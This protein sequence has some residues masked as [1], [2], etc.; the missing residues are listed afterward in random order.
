MKPFFVAF[1]MLMLASCNADEGKV[2]DVVDDNYAGGEVMCKQPIEV[3]YSKQKLTA[4]GYIV[5]FEKSVDLEVVSA[6]YL[7]KYKDLEIYSNF[8]SLNGFHGNSGDKTLQSIQCE[9]SVK[10]I[11]YN[12]PQGLDPKN[13]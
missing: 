7:K 8:S 12:I 5:S 6:E 13:T 11:Q 2:S 1:L 9:A 3:L 10:S 4:K